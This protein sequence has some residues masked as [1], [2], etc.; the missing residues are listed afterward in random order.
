MPGKVE[1]VVKKITN[2]RVARMFQWTSG[3]IGWI[4]MYTVF[5]LIAPLV[6]RVVPLRQAD[7]QPEVHRV[8]VR[9]NNTPEG[10]PTPVVVPNKVH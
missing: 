4:I 5:Y 8:G 10:S 6:R 1:P 2:L 3:G 9:T 7:A